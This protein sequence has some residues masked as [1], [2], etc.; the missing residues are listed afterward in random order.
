MDKAAQGIRTKNYYYFTKK[1]IETVPVVYIC[2][3]REYVSRK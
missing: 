1:S 2:R 3:L